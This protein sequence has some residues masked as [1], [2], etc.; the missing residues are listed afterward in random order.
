MSVR[1]SCVQLL[2]VYMYILCKCEEAI[3]L[4][5]I[6]LMKLIITFECNNK[7]EKKFGI[8]HI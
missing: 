7:K 3:H 5:F 4:Y 6:V 2:C 1:E 8:L